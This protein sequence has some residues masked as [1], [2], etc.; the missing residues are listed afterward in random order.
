MVWKKNQKNYDT[1]LLDCEQSLFCSRICEEERKNQA[2]SK[3]GGQFAHA[4]GKAP[5]LI[6]RGVVSYLAPVA[7]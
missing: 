1:G 2:S 4:S 5:N 7:E 6:P 3:F